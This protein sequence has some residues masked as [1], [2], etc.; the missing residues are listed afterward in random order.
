MNARKWNG[1]KCYAFIWLFWP[2]SLFNRFYGVMVSTPDFESGNPS[3][4]LGR[5]FTSIGNF[6]FLLAF[7]CILHFC[8]ITHCS[9][10]ITAPGIIRQTC[11]QLHRNC[12]LTAVGRS[13]RGISIAI[14]R[15]LLRNREK[16]IRIELKLLISYAIAINWNC[17]PF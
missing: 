3:S 17:W 12:H 6:T 4:N 16:V 15:E 14:E 5:T 8:S 7:P 9:S 1:N 2:F 10:R 13:T 11:R